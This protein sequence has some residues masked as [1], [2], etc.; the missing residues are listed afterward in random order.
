M[1][2]T[3]EVTRAETEDIEPITTHRAEPDPSG[4]GR[5]ATGS[6][7]RYA[8]ILAV[9]YVVAL[10]LFGV[11]VAFKGA[12]PFDAFHT[13]ISSTLLNGNALQQV[14]LRAV[15]IGLAALA[16]AVPARAG[17]INVGGEGQLII[18]AVAATGIGVKIGPHVPGPVAW[19]AM[20][21]GAALAGAAWALIA[22][23]MR[24]SLGASEAVT[25]LLLN[26]IANDIMLYLIYQAWRDP[27]SS[28][29][30]Q[31]KPLVHSAQLPKIFGSQ[32]NLGVP[33]ALVVIGVVWYLIMR[34]GWGFQLRVVG[35]NSEAARRSGLRVRSLLL[36]S[37][38]TG[39]ALAGLGGGLNLAGVEGQLRPEITVTFGYV[40]FLACFLGRHSPVMVVG[41][42]VLFSAIALSGNGLQIN[43][44]LDGTI[45]DVLLALIVAVPL[46]VSKYRRRSA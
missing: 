37:M 8:V 26:F 7:G 34:T 5:F 45:V 35:G 27:E 36:T 43:E 28:G 18:G 25:T 3:P 12:N 1:T 32:L 16:V 41:A 23:V 13:I 24:T 30:P 10:A 38:A 33:I 9:G 31:S 22:G 29:Q 20:C 4:P 11:L 17:L 40:A 2:A 21:V 19:A 6:R 42:A 46:V 14:A 15:P 44:G 39:G